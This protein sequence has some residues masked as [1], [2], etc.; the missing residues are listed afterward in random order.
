MR[1]SSFV[2]GG[3]AA[4]AAVA[5]LS[6]TAAEYPIG[7]HQIQGGM[8]IGAVYLQPI[9]MEP[10][11]MMRKASDSDFHLGSRHP[12]GQEQSD[13]FA[14]GDWMP[15]LQVRYE[16][17]KAGSNQTQK[18]DM[19]AMVANDGPH[20]GDN[21]K[22]QGP[23]K[24]HLKTGRS[25]D[26]NRPHGVRPSRR[27]RNRRGSVVQADHARIRLHVR[28]HRQEGRLLITADQRGLRESSRLAAPNA[29]RAA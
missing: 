22:L 28:G 26:A 4:V 12:R 29:G 3:A 24:Y 5:A 8:E 18:G 7:K 17:T 20:Y 21:V 1:M 14:E 9:T 23:G 11:G 2:R 19:M 16:L 27:Q 15:Y 10:E 25:A 6:A 13:G